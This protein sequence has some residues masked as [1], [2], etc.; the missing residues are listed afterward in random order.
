MSKLLEGG[1]TY[2]ASGWKGDA[3]PD[4]VKLENEVTRK[5]LKRHVETSDYFQAS[6]RF[7]Y[8]RQYQKGETMAGSHT[9]TYHRASIH[10]QK[11][12]VILD[13]MNGYA[14]FMKR[15]HDHRQVA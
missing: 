3:L 15:E 8:E 4:E 6:D 2:Y 5:T 10:G 1:A 13:T 9:V 12:W 11:A 14:V 7:G